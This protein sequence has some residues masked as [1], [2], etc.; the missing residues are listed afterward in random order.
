MG[1]K[2]A[3]PVCYCGIGSGEPKEEQLQISRWGNPW[4]RRA[5]GISPSGDSHGASIRSGLPGRRHLSG[6]GSVPADTHSLEPVPQCSCSQP[7][8]CSFLGMSFH[9]GPAPLGPWAAIFPQEGTLQED[10][11]PA[12]CVKLWI[13]PRSPQRVPYLP[14]SR[15]ASWHQQPSISHA[16]PSGPLKHWPRQISRSNHSY[17]PHLCISSTLSHPKV[18]PACQKLR[19]SLLLLFA[20]RAGPPSFSS[21]AGCFGTCQAWV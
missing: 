15:A 17:P 16:C 5:A 1:P 11:P 6:C 8:S 7:V 19:G 21:Q 13:Q 12:V 3:E 14:P 18:W 10:H 4:A 9:K 2:R 20:L